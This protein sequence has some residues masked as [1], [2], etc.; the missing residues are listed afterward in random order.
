MCIDRRPLL[1]RINE[2]KD[3]KMSV[4]LR[5]NEQQF[6]LSTVYELYLLSHKR[7]TLYFSFSDANAENMFCIYFL[8]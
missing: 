8:K 6:H 3:Q 2:M 1:N 5:T 7:I 4:L